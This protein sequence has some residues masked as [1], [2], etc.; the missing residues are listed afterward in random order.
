MLTRVIALLIL[1]SPALY[2]AETPPTDASLKKLLEVAQVHQT[3]DAMMAQIDTMM[4]NMF[5]QITAGQKVSPEMAKM[6]EKSRADVK[7][8]F[9]E[10]MSWEKLEPMYMRVYRKSLTQ[11]EVDGM[12]AF[13]Q[14]PAGKAV[15]IKMPVILQNSMAEATQMMGPIIQRAQEMEKQLMAEAQKEKVR[16]G[17]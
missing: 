7:E 9:K 8:V 6:F 15:I 16:P 10:T 3:V 2:S 5:Q 14:T 1:L 17:S 13:Y 12:V 4:Q 11:S